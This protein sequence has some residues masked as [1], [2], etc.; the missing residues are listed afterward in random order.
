MI[1]KLDEMLFLN[2]S[3]HLTSSSPPLVL[4]ILS[5]PLLTPFTSSSSSPLLC[6]SPLVSSSL[7]LSSPIVFFT[8]S[9]LSSSYLPLVFPSPPLSSSQSPTMKVE[10]TS[11]PPKCGARTESSFTNSPRR[12]C[13]SRWAFRDDVITLRQWCHHAEMMMSSPRDGA[14][15]SVC[16]C[17][18]QK[19]S[20]FS[21]LCYLFTRIT[22]TAFSS[23][24]W[25][26][27]HA[28]RVLLRRTDQ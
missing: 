18:F 5:S 20:S 15:H 12:S 22:T 25:K 9:L 21:R 14:Q 6:S 16:M 28:H 3:P 27:T 4:L 26:P 2:F 13:A 1:L 8:S 17:L 10:Q 23:S 7:S 11:T 19:H 24:P